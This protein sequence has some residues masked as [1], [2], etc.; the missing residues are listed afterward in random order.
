MLRT[1]ILAFLGLALIPAGPASAACSGA[2]PALTSVAVKSVVQANG[3]KR[4]TLV[5]TVVNSGSEGQGSNVLQFVDI[6]QTPG[7]KLDAKG[8]PPL[9]A[10]ESYTFSYVLLRSTEAGNATTTLRFQLDMR[11]P[12]SSSGANCNTGNDSFTVT[13]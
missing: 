10:G 4:Y 9:K 2:D 1:C 12:A 11:H 7:E 3:V 8:I 6:Y 13:F 5:G